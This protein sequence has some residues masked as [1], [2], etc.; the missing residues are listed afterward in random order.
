MAFYEFPLASG[1][2][3]SVNPCHIIAVF[4]SCYDE[5]QEFSSNKQIPFATMFT[6]LRT[7]DG[8]VYRIALT[9]EEALARVQHV[10]GEE[11]ACPT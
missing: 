7:S 6:F 10:T 8:A 3:L 2:S 4:E 5:A 1:G 9:R 11:G